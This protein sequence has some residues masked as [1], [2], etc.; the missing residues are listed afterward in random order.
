MTQSIKIDKQG[1]NAILRFQDTK[2]LDANNAHRI[3]GEV[4]GILDPGIKNLLID[5]GTIHFVDSTGFGALIAIL[6][7]MKSQGG[8]LILFNVSN[9]LEELMDLMQL[10]TVFEVKPTEKE[11]LASL[12]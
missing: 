5:L 9:E 4:R 1:S 2:N 7:T 3:K 8:K 10:L 6:K 11:A 12:N